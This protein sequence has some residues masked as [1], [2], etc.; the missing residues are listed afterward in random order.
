MAE[1]V[2]DA[3]GDDC[4]DEI[5]SV[6]EVVV[7]LGVARAGHGEDVVVRACRHAALGECLARRQ[8]DPLAGR[9]PL[10]GETRSPG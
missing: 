8:D 10:R 1:D 6:R 7:Q 9:F 4:C 2:L 3:V 5:V